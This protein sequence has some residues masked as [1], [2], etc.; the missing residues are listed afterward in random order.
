MAINDKLNRIKEIKEDIK[1]A[2]IDKGVEVTDEDSFA[3]YADKITNIPQEGGGDPY[4]E[5]L[6]NL[7]T[8]NG[9]DM[10]GLFARITRDSL[11]LT[12]LDISKCTDMSY[13]FDNCYVT[14]LDLS[15]WDTNNVQNIEYM[16]NSSSIDGIIGLSDLKFPKVTELTRTFYSMRSNYLDLSKWDISKIT[17]LDYTF[18]FCSAKKIDLTGWNTSGVT[19]MNNAFNYTSSLTDLIIPDWDMTNVTSSTNFIKNANE[20]KYIDLSRSNDL[21]INKIITFIPTKTEAAYGEMKIPADSSQEVIDALIS[22]YWKPLGPALNP[23]SFEISSELD[24][25][26]INKSTKVHCG[27][28]N[29]WYSSIDGV[30]FISSNETIASINEQGEVTA[31]ALGNVEIYA[32]LKNNPELT[33]N[34]I[35]ITVSETDSTPY[36][37]KFKGTST[38]TSGNKMTIN[39]NTI[40]ISTMDYDQI[41][42]VYTYDAGTEITSI[43]FNDYTNDYADTI[44]ELIKFDFNGN[45]IT[46]MSYM[47]SECSKITDFDF[48]EWDVSN[49]TAIRGMFTRSGF[50]D[51]RSIEK[52][53]VSNISDLRDMFGYSCIEAIDLSHW[54]VNEYNTDINIGSM[55]NGCESLRTVKLFPSQ[56]L[57]YGLSAPNIFAEC[58]SLETVDM[59]LINTTGEGY[60][61]FS[62]GFRNVPSTC[63][64]YVGP[65]WTLTESQCSFTGKFIRVNPEYY[66][67]Y[68]IDSSTAT[69]NMRSIDSINSGAYL[70]ELSNGYDAVL[71]TLNDGSITTDLNTEANQ[72]SSIKIYYPEE[73]SYVKF[74]NTKVKEVNHLSGS[75]I[76]DCTGMFTNCVYLEKADLTSLDSTKVT[77]DTTMFEGVNT[78]A[79]VTFNDSWDIPESDM[80]IEEPEVDCITGFIVREGSYCDFVTSRTTF[81]TFDFDKNV[82]VNF[83]VDDSDLFYLQRTTEENWYDEEY[84]CWCHDMDLCLRA[85]ANNDGA[86]DITIR[87]T[88]SNTTTTTTVHIR[89]QITVHVHY[90]DV[91]GDNYGD[92]LVFTNIETG[93]EYTCNMYDFGDEN[94]WDEGH[95]DCRLPVGMYSLYLIHDGSQTPPFEELIHLASGSGTVEIWVKSDELKYYTENPEPSEPE[96]PGPGNGSGKVY[97]C[98]MC[99][100]RYSAN[101][102]ILN[103][104][105]CSSCGGKICNQRH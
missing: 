23:T 71:L 35:S 58:T 42:G 41:T 92:S 25:V 40:E 37:I 5:E 84:S 66:T 10:A 18:A 15:G 65:N 55:F 59:T 105:I 28:I 54:I 68:S 99:G 95:A 27:N 60:H 69:F 2:L 9:T 1:Q 64:I 39:G 67:E 52:W 38:P 62:G 98:D 49:V 82:P 72:V 8:S 87:E 36:V 17:K 26:L 88:N 94:I 14:N 32:R 103:N 97:E 47:F 43:K 16:F 33:S 6:Y 77:V 31:H 75:N 34:V 80:G 46:D 45:N 13:M 50:R 78:E 76:T 61:G 79:E 11:D 91:T 85:F 102:A 83:V 12:G 100:K 96:E 19:Y 57:S 104:M 81:I 73:T 56:S 51:L 4:Y 74:A 29:P 48:S 21:T 93:S 22:K 86:Y 70:P 3:S 7:R 44:T 63:Q 53:N 89:E 90:K 30:E 24:E 101:E 20:L